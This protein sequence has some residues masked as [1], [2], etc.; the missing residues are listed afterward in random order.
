LSG[1]PGERFTIIAVAFKFNSSTC[2]REA[3]VGI[4]GGGKPKSKAKDLAT[5]D[6][7]YRLADKYE[8]VKKIGEGGFGA[9]FLVRS[10]TTNISVTYVA[11][12]QKLT[13]DPAINKDLISRF[14]Q[15][16]QALQK[17]GNA[18]G[19]IPSLFDFF[20]F[21]GNFYLIQ[22]YIKGKNLLD[23]LIERVE[24]DQRFSIQEVIEIILSLLEVLNQVHSQNIIHRDIKHQNIILRQGDNKPV[25]IDFGIIKNVANYDPRATGT[26]IGTPGY[27]PMEQAAGHVMFQS[28]LYALGVVA[29]VLLTGLS[30]DAIRPN[31]SFTYPDILDA[32]EEHINSLLLDWFKKG[33]AILPQ[34]RF[35][36]AEEMRQDLL[37]VYNLDY[38]AQGLAIGVEANQEKINEMQDEIASLKAQLQASMEAG[39]KQIKVVKKEELAKESAVQ[40]LQNE[41]V[42]KIITTQKEVDAFNIVK[43]IFRDAGLNESRLYLKDTVDFCGINIDNQE[44]KTLVKLYFN[45][46]NKLSFS[47][48]LDK[49][50]EDKYD[51]NTL[52]GI[53]P[54]KD[55][56]LQ[57]AKELMPDAQSTVKVVRS[58]QQG[59]PQQKATPVTEQ[60]S[61]GKD[62]TKYSLNGGSQPYPKGRL[63]LAV[64]TEYLKK[65]PK[66]TFAQLTKTFPDHLQGNLGVVRKLSTVI[67]DKKEARY[68]TKDA[69][70]L[71]DGDQEKIVVCNQWGVD[72]NTKQGNFTD[73]VTHA[74]GLGF[75]I[76]AITN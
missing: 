48:V 11:K 47:I 1:A 39:N 76:K 5:V 58:P 70:V 75:V 32:L 62:F 40:I 22:E 9:A 43:R 3:K 4:F 35:A 41:A 49:G 10:L 17:L 46:E 44:S 27:C 74:Q 34:N 56:I 33:L 7:G 69:D 31:E 18:H 66:A 28:D 8:I 61:G 29:L 64:V 16:A 68:F 57:R 2:R 36:S 12:A 54:K 52:K 72:K 20:E 26:V 50:K 14:Q 21:E 13:N 42:A 15:E 53:S 60:S 30:P 51:I 19:Q 25:L 24:K 59:V 73:F 37:T 38:V 65:H 55:K 63:V 67:A 6:K 23:I 45:D 71:L